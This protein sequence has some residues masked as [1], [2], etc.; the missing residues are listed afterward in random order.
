MQM[1]QPLHAGAVRPLR[2]PIMASVDE[3]VI[4]IKT[5]TRQR[6]I[7]RTT[8]LLLGSALLICGLLLW[9]TDTQRLRITQD[10]LDAPV[11][12]LQAR[13]DTLGFLPATVDEASMEGLHYSTG[14]AERF[15]VS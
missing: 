10:S 14:T 9:R 2:A 3:R 13:I 8:F 12:T 11:R 4:E 6:R 7:L 15:Y 1:I 5:R